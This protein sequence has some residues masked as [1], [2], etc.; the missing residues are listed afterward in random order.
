MT[1]KKNI[2]KEL[3]HLKQEEKQTHQKEVN[4][5]VN[6]TYHNQTTKLETYHKLK[7]INWYHY[8]IA[9]LTSA[10]LVGIC[11]LLGIFFFKDIKKTEWVVV[12]FFIV[13]LLIWLI[14]GWYKNKQVSAYF[15]DH[16]RRYQLTLTDGEAKIKKTRNILL[17]NAGILLICSLII[18]FI[19]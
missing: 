8:L 16:R 11:F 4:E 19:V 12:S 2:F 3:H 6:E 14:L 1:K 17:I 10:S 18:F 7:K 13:I 15:N 5:I 9:I